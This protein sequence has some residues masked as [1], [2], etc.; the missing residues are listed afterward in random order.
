MGA[1]RRAFVTWRA[2]GLKE[3]KRLARSKPDDKDVRAH[4]IAFRVRF[5]ST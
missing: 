3:A 1:Q 2:A 4:A 5:A